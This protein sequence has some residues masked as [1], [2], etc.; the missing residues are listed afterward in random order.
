MLA[1]A[2]DMHPAA[3]GSTSSNVGFVDRC[4][5]RLSRTHVV[6]RLDGMSAKWPGDRLGCLQHV[7][8]GGR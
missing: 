7:G 4:S 8:G 5:G 1:V 6:L 2:Q 3:A